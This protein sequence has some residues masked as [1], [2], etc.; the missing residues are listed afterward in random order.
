MVPANI[1]GEASEEFSRDSAKVYPK[2]IL[3]ISPEMNDYIYYDI[4]TNYFYD[5]DSTLEELESLRTSAQ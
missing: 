3:A 1:E 4:A 5:K 2:E